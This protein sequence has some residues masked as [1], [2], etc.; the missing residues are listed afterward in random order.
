MFILIRNVM[1][2]GEK[3]CTMLAQT[4]KK[5]SVQRVVSYAP[6]VCVCVCVCVCDVRLLN[7]ALVI[8]HGKLIKGDIKFLSKIHYF[9]TDRPNFMGHM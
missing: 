1:K 5:V 4:L 9:P 7:F 6:C 8:L 3:Q 2:I